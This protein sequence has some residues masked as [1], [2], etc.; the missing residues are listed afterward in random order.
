MRGE[1][2]PVPPENGF[3]VKICVSYPNRSLKFSVV[4][5]AVTENL[6]F[7]HGRWFDEKRHHPGCVEPVFLRRI[8]SRCVLDRAVKG[9]G[10][11]SL[12]VFAAVRG[13]SLEQRVTFSGRAI[14]AFVYQNGMLKSGILCS[15][16]VKSP[17][18]KSPVGW[19][20]VT[21]PST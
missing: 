16:I 9:Q 12:L 3:Q 19:Q 8:A 18:V 14:S 2:V 1:G 17:V 10:L 15:L 13:S 7:K 11:V 6:L 21:Y 5:M 4:Q 20:L